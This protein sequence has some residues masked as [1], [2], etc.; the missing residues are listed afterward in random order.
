M[1]DAAD[2]I[3]NMKGPAYAAINAS[4][5]SQRHLLYPIP[6]VEMSLNKKMVQNPYW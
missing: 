6:L 2:E 1:H 4:N 5:V 3:V